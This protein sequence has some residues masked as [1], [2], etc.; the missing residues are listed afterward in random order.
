V[1]W[2]TKG[3]AYLTC[4][5]FQRGAGVTPNP[6]LSSAFYVL[7]STGTGGASWNF[8]GRPV[9]QFDDTA[10]AGTTLLDKPYMTVDTTSGSPFQ[11]GST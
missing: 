8:P 7:R 11:A 3:N 2:D 5:T 4:L 1:A 6:D 9:A 10:A